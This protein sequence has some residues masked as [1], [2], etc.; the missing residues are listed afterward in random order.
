MLGIDIED[1]S[2]FKNKKDDIKFLERIFTK[3][4]IE[5]CLSHKNY[6]AHL[7]ARFCA[8][9]AVIKALTPF[10]IKLSK[11]SLI[12]LYHGIYGE[13]RIRILDDN[14]SD[15][16]IDI[17]ISHD[18]TKSIAIAMVDKTSLQKY[19]YKPCCIGDED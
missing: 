14:Y 3:S 10:G 2:R 8:K 11:M 18:K 15:I 12:E 16:K 17:S 5:Y 7:C 6:S 4:E 13:A 19:I 9:E 1:N